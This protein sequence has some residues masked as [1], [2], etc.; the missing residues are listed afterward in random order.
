M[1]IPSVAETS[2][3]HAASEPHQFPRRILLAV[4]G[5][6]PQ[7]VT[8][9][10]FML[11]VRHEP[12]F[13]PT[14]IHLITTAE[15]ADR[16]RLMLFSRQPGWL[17]RLRRDYG[18]PRLAFQKHQIHVLDQGKMRDIRTPADNVLLADAITRSI[19]ELTSDPRAALHV[20]IAGGRKTMGF[21]A[22]Y[23]LSL[24]GRPQDRLSHV[25]V[26]SPY[27][28]NPDFFYPSPRPRIIYAAHPDK[29]PLDAGQ[30]RL[31]LA[32]IPFVRLREGLPQ[33]LLRGQASFSQAVQALN[34]ALAAPS[35]RFDLV[36]RRAVCGGQVLR[37]PAADLAFFAWFAR[38]AAN[39]Q[40]GLERDRI[41]AALAADFLSEYRR[42]AAEGDYQ[43]AASLLAAGMEAED[44]DARRSR[45]HRKLRVQLGL[46]ARHY[47]IQAAGRRP[48]TRYALALAPGQIHFAP[49]SGDIR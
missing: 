29:K 24:Y 38:R 9:T 45:L 5:L 15:G 4:I 7:V 49:V 35:L 13:V 1:S 44:F 19:G 32:E 14:E 23:A 22:G 36:R 16:V 30:A 48:V 41:S 11:A 17:A 39:H 31:W 18:L 28:N 46:A 27:E 37:L 20:S 21:Y 25:L 10:L 3:V 33:N 47:L 6:S 8:E 12:P 34:Q 42:L 2:A 26:A 40:L 43:K